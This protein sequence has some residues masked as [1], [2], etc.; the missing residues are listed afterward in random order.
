MASLP[1][2]RSKCH[3][4]SFRGFASTSR[5]PDVVYTPPL[6]PGQL[7]AYDEAVAL[8]AQDREAKLKQLEELRAKGTQQSVLDDLETRAWIDDPEV[9]WR[10]R[11]GHGQPSVDF[12]FCFGSLLTWI[13]DGPRG[14]VVSQPTCLSLCIGDW[15]TW[16]GGGTGGSGPW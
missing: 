2:L 3:R 9:R 4:L 13:N 5:F 7:P 16:L 12:L 10:A 6:K 1:A 14:A 11:N 15:R 8:I